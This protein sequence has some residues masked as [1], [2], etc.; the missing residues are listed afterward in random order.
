MA[1]AAGH[2]EA[3]AV[4]GAKTPLGAEAAMPVR[5]EQTLLAVAQ[6]EPVQTIGRQIPYWN[7]PEPQ[8]TVA[9]IVLMRVGAAMPD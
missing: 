8:E 2:W 7:C 3:A 4:A 5:M 1:V 9:L 6:A